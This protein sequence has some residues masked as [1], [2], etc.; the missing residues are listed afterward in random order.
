MASISNNDYSRMITSNP[1]TV[2]YGAEFLVP[3]IRKRIVLKE[4]E[5]IEKNFNNL[6]Y[7]KAEIESKIS[8]LG[9][10]EYYFPFAYGLSTKINASFNENTINFHRYRS[11]LITDTIVDLLGDDL[12]NCSVLDMACHCG[13]FS[14]DLASKGV[15]TVRGIEYR[16]KN[17]NQGLF[18]KNYYGVENVLFEQGDVYELDNSEY[19]VIMCLGILYHVIR[20]VDLIEYCYKHCNKFAV[21][22]TVCHKEPISAYKVV[23]DKNVEVAI[24]GTRK[25][26]LQPTYRAVIETMQ[27]VGFVKIIEVI[28]DCDENI[29][30]FSDYSRRCFI[31][32]K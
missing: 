4:F 8:E 14:M 17:L 26:E 29:E 12:P 13:V 5:F 19:D 2:G 1:V 21:I 30:L 10:W 28:G 16:E 20:P 11:Q 9:H 32:F 7:S 31:G 25:I 23:G 18:L 24:E 15:K 22:E 27:Q 3:Q 6:N